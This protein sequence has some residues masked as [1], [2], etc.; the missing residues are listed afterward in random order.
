[1]AGLR[2]YFAAVGAAV[3]ELASL[4]AGIRAARADARDLSYLYDRPV[5]A[6]EAGAHTAP[7]R[8]QSVDTAGRFVVTGGDDRTVRIWSVADGKLLKTIRIPVGPGNVGRIFAVAISPDGSTIAAG[9]WTGSKAIWPIYVFDRGSGTLIKSIIEDV[10]SVTNDLAFSADGRFLAAVLGGRHGLRIYQAN[11]DWREV[12]ADSKYGDGSNGVA[13]ATDGDVATVADDG[14]LRLYAYDR[15]SS[16]VYFRLVGKP[17]PTARGRKPRG[18]AFSPDGERL[19]FGYEDSTS[20]DVLDAATLRQLMVRE[21]TDAHLEPNGFLRTA[22]SRDSQTLFATGAVRDGAQRNFLFAWDSQGL[23]SER[24]LKYCARNTGIGVDQLADGSV[25]VASM[26]PCL[27]LDGP[28][29]DEIWSVYSPVLNLSNETD[30]MRVS[31]DGSVVDFVVRGYATPFRFDTRSLTLSAAARDDALTFPPNRGGLSVEGWHNSHNV[32]IA[33]VSIPLAKVDISRSLAIEPT[34]NGFYLGSSFRLR[35]FD[36]LGRE[37][38][39]R[40]AAYGE[41]WAVNASQDGRLLV[42]ANSDGT[43]RWHRSNDGAEL[44]SLQVLPKGDDVSQWDWVLW[45]PDGFYDATEGAKDVLRWVVNHGPDQAAATKPV[46]AIP[47]LHRRTALPRILE[48]LDPALALGRDDIATARSNVKAGTQSPKAP[49]PVLHVLTIGIDKFGDAAHGLHLDYAAQDAQDVAKALL[50]SQTVA[51]S[52]YADVEPE[53]PLID[54]KASRRQINDALDRIAEKMRKHEPVQ[55]VAVIFVSTHGE[56]IGDLGAPDHSQ[57]YLAPYG[58]DISTKNAS[59]DTG[60][61]LTNFLDKV[62]ELAEH[63]KVL[64]LIDACHSGAAEPSG[65]MRTPNA[66]QIRKT[67]VNQNVA[68][69]MSSSKDEL[70]NELPEYGHGAFAQAFLDALGSAGDH[71]GV[72]SLSA[73]VDSMDEEVQELT[74]NLKYKQHLGR[75]LN[76]NT[77]LFVASHE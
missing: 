45:T 2:G 40:D 25:L 31:A 43:I 56:M 60:L 50:N 77:K 61:P 59:T 65:W 29:G 8:S 57:F 16:D 33:D 68:V 42:A 27:G 64:L 74:K 12:F 54:Q 73:L 53:E 46:S 9:G 3:V 38:W 5:L 36:A 20:V 4:C 6:I 55:D 19:A 76:F 44:L 67:L 30:A 70:S 1:M 48:T 7:I 63:G 13:F 37:R 28:N 34:A 10:P 35:A 66:E 51:P 11:A 75:N 52:L 22:W 26:E 41:V 39:S 72:V 69:L 62:S 32:H 23:G 18:I 14:Y 47:G 49:G 15:N 17:E 71:E 24:R 58:F 21:P